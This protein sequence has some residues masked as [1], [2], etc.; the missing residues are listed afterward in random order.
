MLLNKTDNGWPE[1]PRVVL[2]RDRNK[3]EKINLSHNKVSGLKRW[4]NPLNNSYKKL[5]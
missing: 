2:R 4:E 1:L 3:T 5:E